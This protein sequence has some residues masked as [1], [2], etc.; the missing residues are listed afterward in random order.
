M[1]RVKIALASAL[2]LAVSACGGSGGAD[3]GD[4]G[5]G[6]IDVAF[7][8]DRSGPGA[9]YG[10]KIL[11]GAQFNVD[12]INAA[13]GVGGREIRME[14]IDSASQQQQAVAAVTRAA[15]TGVDAIMYGP[16]S[17]NALA[18]AP[19]AQREQVPLVISYAS[20]DAITEAGDYVFR[21]STSEGRF[22]EGMLAT[23]KANGMDSTAILYANDVATAVENAEQVLPRLAEQ[24][25]VQITDTVAVGSAET[26]YSAAVTQIAQENPD[27]VAMLVLGPAVT[28]SITALR[29]TGFDGVLFGSSALGAGALTDA[30]PDAADTYY[31]ASYI[32]SP[33]LPWA[34]GVQF[35]QDYEAAT[36]TPPDSFTAAG[37]DQ[38]EFLQAALEVIGD[39]EVTRESIRDALAQV[40]ETGF[41]GATGTPVKF[42]DNRIAVTPGVLVRWDGSAETLA[43]GQEPPLLDAYATQP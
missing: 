22:Y 28:S 21:T 13:G 32:P 31:P 27:G 4:N 6:P 5:I 8:A 41:E 25:G 3:G 19:V 11:E 20:V 23:L 37:H 40:T 12:R 30:G 39:G 1:R 42:D 18:M 16:L 36:G 15:R 9:L 26:D 24:Y 35:T 10:D 2:L 33:D 34:S 14:I 38:I 7:I 17:A 29:R 43:P